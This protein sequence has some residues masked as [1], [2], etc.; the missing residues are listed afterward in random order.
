MSTIIPENTDN[1]L[2]KGG[3]L[4]S[5]FYGLILLLDALVT[6]NVFGKANIKVTFEGRVLSSKG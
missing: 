6:T 1:L 3:L 2:K 5:I 4:P